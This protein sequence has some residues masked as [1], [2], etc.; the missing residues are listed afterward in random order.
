MH[1]PKEPSIYY[2]HHI[3]ADSSTTSQKTNIH[4]I[5]P[6]S[7]PICTSLARL[8]QVHCLPSHYT[9]V[10]QPVRICKCIQFVACRYQCG[11]AGNAEISQ[12]NTLP[13]NVLKIIKQ[14]RFASTRSCLTEKKN[15]AQKLLQTETLAC[16]QGHDSTTRMLR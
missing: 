14:Q 3:L 5:W 11:N 12:C 16:E 2:P 1:F 10:F 15:K 4:E 7:D 9:V 6:R 13:K 8:P